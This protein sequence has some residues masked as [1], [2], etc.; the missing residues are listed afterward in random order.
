MSLKLHPDLSFKD[1]KS[2]GTMIQNFSLI[3]RS[4]MTL[5][6]VKI[7]FMRKVLAILNFFEITKNITATVKKFQP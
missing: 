3:F 5:R 4:S 2:I 6:T 1:K 7:L